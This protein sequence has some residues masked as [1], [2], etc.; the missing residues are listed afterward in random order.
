MKKKITLLLIFVMVMSL[1]TACGGGGGGTKSED[2][3]VVAYTPDIFNTMVPY[4][5]TANSDQ[6]VFDQVYE[7]LA[8]TQDDGSVK[9]CLAEDWTISDGGLEYTF[10]LVQDATFHN[11]ENMKASDVVFSYEKF[12]ETAAKKNFVEM[13]EKVEAVDDYTVK[14]TLNKVTPS[15]WYTPMKC[16]S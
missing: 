16:L 8:I 10:N 12:M 13:I 9:G 6:M 5:T 15:S 3:A 4:D 1:F 14:F 11:G 2:D 7:T